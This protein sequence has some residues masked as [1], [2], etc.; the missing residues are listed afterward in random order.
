MAESHVV[1]GLV[2]KRAELAGQIDFHR[3]ALDKIGDDLRHIDATIKLF[4]PEFDL[5]TVK[6]T[7]HR[8]RNQHF[9]SGEVPRSTLDVLREHGGAMTSRQIVETILLRKGIEPSN[10]HIAQLQKGVLAVLRVQ[11]ARQI[12]V[13][14]DSIGTARAWKL[15]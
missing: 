14:A 11:E 1:T 7:A 10:E 8:T 13:L 6:A 9:K 4:A 15:A 2:A 3:K 12:V 5:R